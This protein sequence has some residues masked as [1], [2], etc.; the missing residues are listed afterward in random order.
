MHSLLTQP[1]PDPARPLPRIEV[2]EVAR[3]AKT[4]PV[5]GVGGHD[6]CRGRLSHGGACFLRRTSNTCQAPFSSPPYFPVQK[7][8]LRVRQVV[9][10]SLPGPSVRSGRILQLRSTVQR[11]LAELHTLYSGLKV[12]VLLLVTP[13][14]FRSPSWK[15]YGYFPLTEFHLLMRLYLASTL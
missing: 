6:S 2:Q 10:T 9:F 8:L 7:Q 14:T 13:P 1:G 15:H 11:E 3:F 4:Q 12:R 5:S